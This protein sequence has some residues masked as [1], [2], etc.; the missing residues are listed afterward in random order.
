MSVVNKNK[1][2]YYYNIFL[3]KG[4]YKN[5]W[6]FVYYKGYSMAKLT[7]L[8]KWMLIK[9]ASVIFI[10]QKSVIFVII[11]SFKLQPNVYNSCHDLLMMS[12]NLS[13][14]AILNIEDS[15][16]C[17]IISFISKNEATNLFQNADLNEKNWTS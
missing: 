11:G 13:D 10:H 14:T 5:K 8:K 15:D 7:F 12:I 4:L 6:V 17:C 3:E 9:Q 16:Y 2:K 1:N